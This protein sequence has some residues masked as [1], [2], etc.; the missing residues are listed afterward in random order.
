MFNSRRKTQKGAHCFQHAPFVVVG[1]VGSPLTFAFFPTG[2]FR[3]HLCKTLHLPF[4]AC[5][6]PRYRAGASAPWSFAFA[7]PPGS[8]P[9]ARSCRITGWSFDTVFRIAPRSR[10]RPLV[11]KVCGAFYQYIA[12]LSSGMDLRPFAPAVSRSCFW[13]GSLVRRD[14]LSLRGF[15][16]VL[17]PLSLAYRNDI[18]CA[19]ACRV[20][21]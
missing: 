18:T 13:L 3:A 20:L 10:L 15:A 11:L 16:G 6:L 17:P 4:E 7:F 14:V 19:H 8:Q 9:A 1:P 21:L 5:F 12:L 2:T